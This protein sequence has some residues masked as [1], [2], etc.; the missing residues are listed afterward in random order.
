MSERWVA[1]ITALTRAEA[2]QIALQ[3]AAQWF[4]C[5]PTDLSVAMSE[6][7][8]EYRSDRELGG[9]LQ[10]YSLGATVDVRVTRKSGAGNRSGDR[11]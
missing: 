7:T 1:T 5:D 2:E 9:H 3:H 6:A 11:P 4:G 8:G 10:T